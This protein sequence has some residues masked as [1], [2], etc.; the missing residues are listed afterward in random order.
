MSYLR[1]AERFADVAEL[2]STIAVV[3][4]V[5]EDVPVRLDV[6]EADR[7]SGSDDG[8]VNGNFCRFLYDAKVRLSPLPKPCQRIIAATDKF[9]KDHRHSRHGDRNGFSRC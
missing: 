6:G 2:G 3:V 7:A 9:K 1:L 8:E 4:R 5:S